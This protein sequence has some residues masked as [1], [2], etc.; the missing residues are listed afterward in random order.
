V[1]KAGH[2]GTLDPHVSGVLPVAL[3][4]ATRALDALLHGDKEYVCAMKLHSDV[5]KDRIVK[6]I[7]E[8]TGI[9]FQTPPLKSAVKKE[10]RTRRIY[11]I[12]VFEVEDRNVLFKVRCEAGTYI[13]MLCHDI[14]DALLTGAHMEGLR[15]TRVAHLREEDTV[16][17]QEVR[18]A[19]EHWKE[20][21]DE[22]HLRKVLQ[23][24]EKLFEHLPKVIIK[25]TAVDAVCHGANL[26]I[27]GIAEADKRIAKG[28]F[29]ALMTLKGECVALGTALLS[30]KQLAKKDTGFAVDTRRVLM[31]TGTYPMSWKKRTKS[32]NSED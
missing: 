26:A 7:G 13:R 23:P 21:G 9:I 20:T 12:D 1:E 4:D 3:M 19:F 22:K 8:F 27:P 30:H 11:A 18:D 2:G 29:V 25:D 17:L 6:M 5:P 10:L 24:T 31:S 15:R 14:G 16:T 28:D 32:L